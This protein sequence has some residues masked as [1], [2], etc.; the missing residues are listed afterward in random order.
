[1]HI[2][3]G[4]LGPGVAAA[5]WVVAGG[6]LAVALRTERREG[7][8]MPAGILGSVAA[9][10]FA[11]QA[12][13]VPV[14]AGTS[15]HLVGATLAALL[16]GPWRALL[17]MAAVLSVQALLFQDGGIAAWGA[18]FVD[19]GLAGAFVGYGVA[20][21]VGT[22]IRGP[23]G[24]VAGG[25]LGAFAATLSG[26]TLVACWL[27]LSGLYPPDGI[28]PLMIVTHVPIGVLEGALTGSIL[29]TLLRWRPD[30][31]HQ[32]GG[33]AMIRRPVV[34]ATGIGSVAV[35]AA[36][37]MA[38]LSSSLPDGLETTA[39]T[40]GFASRAHPL[41]HAPMAGYALLAGWPALAAPAIAGAIGTVAAAVLAWALSRSLAL[42]DDDAH[43]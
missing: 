24:V 25:V 1:V 21:L 6:S 11:A 30:L 19:M 31:V 8:P 3:D 20:R 23:R 2:P 41:W 12:I 39:R 22:S 43:R 15:G 9:F 35:L 14:A 10:V 38:P 40:L 5:T 28:L 4:F 16:L 17:A 36:I 13:N 37:V 42:R 33:P 26:A 29:A 18:N 27:G 34:V 7:Q 32:L